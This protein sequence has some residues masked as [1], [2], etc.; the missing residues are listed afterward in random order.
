M[1][2]LRGPDHVFE[3]VNAAYLQFVGNRELLGKSV[4]EAI[5]EVTGQ[6]YLE[7]LDQVYRT[8]QT[9][10]GRSM[11][12]MLQRD[13]TAAPTETYVNFV[14]Q[15]IRDASGAVSGIFVEGFDVTDRVHSEMQLRELNRELEE[16]VVARTAELQLA[17]QQLQEEVR[18]RE[19]AQ[20]ALR[21]AQKMESIGQ[22]TGGV[23][24]DFNN[25][26][27][28]IMGGLERIQRLAASE[29]GGVQRAASLAMQGAQRAAT[30]TQRLLAFSR[31]QPLDPKPTDINRLVMGTAALLHRTLGETVELETVLYPRAWPIDIDRNQMETA[32]LNL[33]VNARDAMPEGGQLTIE[34]ANVYLDEAYVAVTP[35]LQPGQ[36]V[37]IS[38]SDTG[39]GMRPEIL[40][41]VFEPF[42]TTKEVGRGT[43]L[44]LSQVY[45]FIKQSGGHVRVYSEP[46]QG[47]TVRLYLPRHL[48]EIAAPQPDHTQ[49]QPLRA[50][51]EVVLVVEDDAQV[52]AHTTEVLREL[53]YHVLEAEDARQA[54]RISAAAERID[55]LFTDV[56][57][58]GGRSGRQLAEALL[59]QRPGTKVLY[60]TGYARNA[61]VHHGRLD[62]GTALITKPFA[63]QDL[64][65]K[66]WT[67]LNA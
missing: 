62:P 23:A 42:F 57:L 40:E 14:Y 64:A 13:P 36:Y 53:G 2:M 20:A 44:G 60:T 16:R 37:S 1:C 30:L 49:Q 28:V 46:A 56:V 54:L 39:C 7:L 65:V 67:V 5:W 6:G 51:G 38:V 3:F 26:L 58:P 4:R 41:R 17:L 43:G 63:M 8:G 59:A 31:R 66:V 47:T 22:L 11:R 12:L 61:I 48:G 18:E 19:A 15:P 21:Q 24:H 29:D 45:G 32:L 33:A 52:R 27:T 55:L 9:F 25:L 35:E 50:N 10:T 34:T